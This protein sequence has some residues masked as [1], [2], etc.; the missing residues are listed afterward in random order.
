[1]YLSKRGGKAKKEGGCGLETLES[2]MLLKAGPILNN[3]EKVKKKKTEGSEHPNNLFFYYYFYYDEYMHH[4]WHILE[5]SANA[6]T[7]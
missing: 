6:T 4:S 7:F 1:M 5:T 3:Y 2:T